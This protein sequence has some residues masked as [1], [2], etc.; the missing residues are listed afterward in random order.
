[1]TSDQF[2]SQLEAFLWPDV[3]FQDTHKQRI[4]SLLT[5]Y[6]PPVYNTQTIVQRVVVEKL[7]TPEMQSVESIDLDALSKE[8]ME[9]YNVS[10]EEFMEKKRKSR[11]MVI[12]ARCLFV[13]SVLYKN[14]DYSKSK[15]GRYLDKHHTSI[16][17]YAHECKADCKLPALPVPKN[18]T[19]E[20]TNR[21]SGR[22]EGSKESI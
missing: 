11:D 22:I 3:S 16:I 19:H 2:I 18:Y 10:R 1:M 15:L 7:I 14:L 13:R 17:Y 20:R 8:A 9:Q 6:K 5:E 4:K 12:S 21:N